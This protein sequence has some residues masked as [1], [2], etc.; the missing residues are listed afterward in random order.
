VALS[1]DQLKPVK[2]L[3]EWFWLDRYIASDTYL[4]PIESRGLY[5]EMRSRAWLRGASLPND[6]ALIQR[7]IGATADEWARCWPQIEHLWRVVGDS[8][9]CDDQLEVY[10]EAARRAT[11]ASKRGTDAVNE[12]WRRERERAQVS[13]Q[14]IP[15]H[16]LEKCPPSPSPSPSPSK[17]QDLYGTQRDSKTR[18]SVA[19]DKPDPAVFKYVGSR[20]VVTHHQ[21]AKMS[22][23]AVSKSFDLLGWYDKLDAEMIKSRLVSSNA[24]WIR[25]QFCRA[26]GLRS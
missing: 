8:L 16:V 9:V 17:D 23:V 14:A 13:T 6:H 18:Q 26:T 5:R 2:L 24:K 15:E 11:K 7:M 20:L 4:L 21:H 10:A 22:R 1:G 19:T 25:E 3:A 12:R